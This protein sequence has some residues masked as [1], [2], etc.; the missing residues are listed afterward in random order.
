[1]SSAVNEEPV[2]RDAKSLKGS[3]PS[4]PVVEDF[5]IIETEHALSNEEI[6]STVIDSSDDPDLNPWTFRSVSVGFGLS[7]FGS[8]LA[9]IYYFKPQTIF[10]NTIFLLMLAYVLCEALS[11]GIPRHTGR[12]G[13]TWANPILKF[14]NPHPFNIKEHVMIVIMCSTASTSA[15]A[16]EVLAVQKLWYHPVNTG[17]GIFLI[18]SSQLIGY[19]IVGILRKT[20][21]Y[22][23]KMFYPNVL[24][25]VSTLQILHNDK[26]GSHKKLKMFYIAFF[27][28]FVWEIVPEWMFGLLVGFSVPCLAAPNSRVVSTLFGGTNGNEGLGILSFCFDWNY[29]AGSGNPMAIPLV[30]TCNSLFGYFLCIIV[31]CGVYYGNV[32]EAKRFPFLSQSLF[33]FNST[34]GNYSLF[35]QTYILDKQNVLNVTALEEV[36]VPY[37]T[38][39]YTV[40]LIATNLSIAATFTHMYL[41][42][43]DL[44]MRSLGFADPRNWKSFILIVKDRWRFWEKGEIDG[45]LNVDASIPQDS[46]DPH[47]RAMLR[48]QEVPHW[49][50]ILVLLLSAMVA[51]VC[52]YE[53]HS[54]MPCWAFIIAIILALLFTTVLGGLVGM[55]GFGGTQM[56]TVIQLI[57]SYLH[58]GNPMANMYFT[59][60]GYNLV[61]QAFNML[62][63]LKQAQYV[64]LSPRSTFGAQLFGTIV[65]SVFN[66]LMMVTIVN[67]QAEILKSPEGTDVWSGQNVQQ[68][69]TQGI[70]WGALA[71]YMYSSGK[72]YE[73]VPFALLLGFAIPLPF[74]FLHKLFPKA[75]FRNVN[76]PIMVWYI[77]QLCAGVNSPITSY[78]IVAF[79]SQWWLRKYH[80]KV[81]RDYNYILAAGLTGGAQVMVFILSFA[82]AGASGSVHSF[83]TWWGNNAGGN[84]DRCHFND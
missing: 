64:K 74:Y 53:S 32:W 11:N 10:V 28:M 33:N 67:N 36:G 15:L 76:M 71:K 8:V 43:W 65:G 57:G 38:G 82:V 54:G 52:S 26:S 23:T 25:Q 42:H 66:Y 41:Y 18:F 17:L 16:T 21:V 20:L 6:V 37:L 27:C 69:N 39:T 77:G 55:F 72:R 61:Q 79:A 68:Y 9:E 84:F 48:Y 44:M 1:M 47:F 30:A 19:G 35:D 73:W 60:Y 13:L 24:P 51:L 31:F 14:L 75:G 45:R 62:Q 46:D 50:Y 5:E 49:W 56:Q 34:P 22:P 3:I 4:D 58:P 40:Y 12:A 2:D 7:V 80:P 78:F 29:I 83:P 63:D 81:F 59:L 70:S